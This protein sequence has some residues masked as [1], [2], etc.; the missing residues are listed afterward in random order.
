MLQTFLFS[1][2]LW[3]IPNSSEQLQNF[4]QL[5]ADTTANRIQFIE[6]DWNLAKQIAQQEKKLIFVDVYATWCLPCMLLKSKTF[7]NKKVSAFFNTHF[8]NLSVDAEKGVGIQVARY[9]GVTAYP[10]LVFTDASGKPVLY[11]MGYMGPKA[12]LKFANAALAKAQK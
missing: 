10:T 8:V 9:F 6:Q 11:A 4:H 12:F 1:L 7:H 5:K 2:W 3:V